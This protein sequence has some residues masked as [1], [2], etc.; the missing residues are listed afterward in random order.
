MS[1]RKNIF[2]FLAFLGLLSGCVKEGPEGPVGPPGRDGRDGQDGLDTEIYYSDWYEPI[3]WA[4]QSGDWYFDVSNSAITEDM[5]NTGIIL[6][7]VSFQDDIYEWAVRPMPAYA[8]GA[9]WDFVLPGAGSIEFLCDMPDYPGTTGL[10]FR[11]ILIPSNI[12]VKKS[13]S[14]ENNLNIEELKLLPYSEVCKKLGIP[15]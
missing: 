2:L 5:L 1:M 8:L 10:L 15:E 9:N 7:Y 13:G 4:G 14:V 6:A 3:T 11:F 12:P